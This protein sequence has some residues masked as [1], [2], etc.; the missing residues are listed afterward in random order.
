[1]EDP[2]PVVSV[3]NYYTPVLARTTNT[4]PV[5]GVQYFV[6]SLPA[7]TRWER[8]HSYPVRSPQPE[9]DKRKCLRKTGSRPRDG[10]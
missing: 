3:L 5:L 1:M 10:F 7:L 9:V 2:Q 4:E 6:R 8:S